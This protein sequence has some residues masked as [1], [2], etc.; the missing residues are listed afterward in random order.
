MGNKNCIKV[1]SVLFCILLFLCV[2]YFIYLNFNLEDK[3]ELKKLYEKEKLNKD[4]IIQNY[5]LNFSNKDF[6][7]FVSEMIK[8]RYIVLDEKNFR[9]SIGKNKKELENGYYDIMFC[10]EDNT[11]EV[12]VNKLFKEENFF[13][14]SVLDNDYLNEFINLIESLTK[15]TLNETEKDTFKN[16][17]SR[18]Y[19][20]IKDVESVDKV[21]E[22]ISNECIYFSLF[23]VN[24]NNENNMLKISL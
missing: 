17:I 1:V 2:I 20:Y 12:Y 13:K 19:L 11:L 6:L 10:I 8:Q 22:K 7:P 15:V 23:K 24:L 4:D 3:L 16:S 5:K 18:N 9:L 21:E 14:N